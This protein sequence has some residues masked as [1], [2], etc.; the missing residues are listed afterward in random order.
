MAD[1]F[2]IHILGDMALFDGALN[3]VAMLFKDTDLLSGKGYLGLGFGAFFGAA[4]LLC[5]MVYNAAF[6]QQMEIRTLILPLVVYIILTVPKVDVAISDV[7]TGNVRKVD[8]IPIGLAI[9]ASVASGISKILTD[10]FET[11][12]QTVTGTEYYMPRITQDGYVTPLKLI[13]GLR[14][15]AKNT[16]SPYLLETTK[17]FYSQCLYKN[18]NFSSNDLRTA[19]NMMAYIKGLFNGAEYGVTTVVGVQGSSGAVTRTTKSCN[20]AYKIIENNINSYVDGIAL[21]NSDLNMVGDTTRIN[22]MNAITNELVGSGDATGAT[23]NFS[24][25][26]TTYGTAATNTALFT[27]IQKMAGVTED[28]GRIFAANTLLNPLLETASYCADKNADVSQLSKCTAWVSS[29]NQWEEKNAAA[30]TGFLK[31][32]KDGQNIL[33]MI[34]FLFFPIIVIFIMVQGVGSFKILGQYLAFTVAAYLWLPIASII[35]FYIQTTLSDEFF[36]IATA[37]G[38]SAYLNMVTGPQFYAAVSQKLAL[39]NGLLA[40]VPILSM[41]LFG[42][43]MMGMSSLA[44]RMNSADGGDYDSKVNS[45]DLYKSAPLASSNSAVTGTGQ[46]QFHETASAKMTISAS[47]QSASQQSSSSSFGESGSFERSQAKESVRLYMAGAT[48]A[49]SDLES[50]GQSAQSDRSVQNHKTHNDVEA[51]NTGASANSAENVAVSNL[52]SAANSRIG[53]DTTNKGLNLGASAGPYADANNNPNEPNKQGFRAQGGFSGN[54]GGN[55]SDAALKNETNANSVQSGNSEQLA[56]LKSRLATAQDILSDKTGEKYSDGAVASFLNSVSNDKAVNNAISAK[57]GDME[58]YTQGR[59][60]ANQLANTNSNTYS[61]QITGSLDDIGTISNYGQKPEVQSAITNAYNKAS[62]FDQK[63]FDQNYDDAYHSTPVKNMSE[64]DKR[65]YALAFAG[66]QTGGAISNATS[67]AAFGFGKEIN[68]VD[69]SKLEENRNKLQGEVD[70]NLANVHSNLQKANFPSTPLSTNDATGL[71]PPPMET[72][73]PNRPQQNLQQPTKMEA[74]TPK[75]SGGVSNEQLANKLIPDL[76]KQ[77]D[78][79]FNKK[80]KL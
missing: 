52:K 80:N 63:R 65:G 1:P 67:K 25:N 64:D 30:A 76:Q 60:Y 48:K 53:A 49:I 57:Q 6:K 28:D 11:G 59:N 29:V 23:S 55:T 24:A 39:A 32:M 33:I 31:I 19:P 3:G 41:M 26:M 66:M 73:S 22:L 12:L 47:Q 58:T 77:T 8:N 38:G 14:L 4:I 15:V 40:S 61:Q 68:S 37:Q 74:P 2:V 21:Q 20:A 78:N 54:I 69:T 71:K 46:G 79:V 43:M 75:P 5:V 35:N 7:Y 56:A 17:N 16:P 34:S 44:S 10:I 18:P 70:T 13:N 72:V 42:G 51:N 27:A 50:H 9:P 36:K 62:S 45:P